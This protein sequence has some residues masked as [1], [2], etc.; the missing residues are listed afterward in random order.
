MMILVVEVWYNRGP[1]MD[2][3]GEMMVVD[4]YL[5]NDN[6]YYFSYCFQLFNYVIT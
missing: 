6:V 2:S 1:P 3:R 5:H 4:G